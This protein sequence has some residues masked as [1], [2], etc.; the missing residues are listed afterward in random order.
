MERQ[1]VSDAL[2][3]ERPDVVHT[4]GYHADVLF[5]S[6]AQQHALPVIATVHG[7]TGGKLKN[8]MFEWLERRSLRFM[9]GVVAVSQ[10]LARR[11]VDSGVPAAK[12]HVVPN[13]YAP[14]GQFLPRDAAR[15]RLGLEPGVRVI[16]WVGRVTP[17][18]GPDVMLRSH[19]LLADQNTVLCIIGR[20]RLEPELRRVAQSLGIEQR[21]RWAGAVPDAW[22]FFKAFDVYC[23]SSHTEGTPMALLEAIAAG[24]PVVTTAVGGIPVVVGVD[25]AWLVP[26]GDAE[27]LGEALQQAL[28]DPGSRPAAALERL[29]RAFAVDPWLD[30]YESIYRSLAPAD[31][32]T[33]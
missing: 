32:R 12:V 11:L 21:I 15:Q 8:R 2:R 7:F 5:R 19:A 9:D 16:G 30:R 1:L 6:V 23:L 22:Q 17:E 33:A 26:P 29:S 4:H 13:A 28:D 31:T 3:T 24:V 20:G 14:P 25:Q 18:K 10:P 27:A